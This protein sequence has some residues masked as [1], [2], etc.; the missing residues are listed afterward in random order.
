MIKNKFE[1]FHFIIR[2]KQYIFSVVVI[3]IFVALIAALVSAF[4]GPRKLSP[5]HSTPTYQSGQ[6]M[7]LT[8]IWNSEAVI[9]YASSTLYWYS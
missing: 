9:W 1:K 7:G 8:V 4:L 5:P 2:T 6:V 3:A